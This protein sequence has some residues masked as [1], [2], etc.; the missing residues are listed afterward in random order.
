MRS[1]I[2]GVNFPALDPV[3]LA[4]PAE[5]SPAFLPAFVR[6]STVI[7][8]TLRTMVPEAYFEAIEKF[9]DPKT[10]HPMLIY[11]ASPPFRGKKRSELTYDV[12]NPLSMSMLFRRT[13]PL[14]PELLAGTEQRLLAAGCPDL[15]DQYAPKRANAILTGVQRLSKSRR[16]LCLLIRGESVLV[17]TLIQLGGIGELPAKARSERW[18]SFGKRWNYH[19]RRLFPGLNFVHQ[20]PALLAAASHAMLPPEDSSPA[21]F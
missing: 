9:R 12:L 21:A 11:Q 6:I 15:A 2:P 8:S 7:Q 4:T 19:L 14:L 17:D 16:Y 13:K 3:W 1:I 5:R 18:A 20:A 10:A